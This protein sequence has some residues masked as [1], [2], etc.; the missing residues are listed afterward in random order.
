M[1]IERLFVTLPQGE[2]H[3]A[4]A[5]SGPPVLLLHQTP[6]SWDEY[7]DVLPLLGARYRAIAMDTIGFGDSVKPPLAAGADSI[8]NWAD[9]AIALLNVLE[10]ERAAVVGHHTGAAIAIELSA[11]HPD[12]ITG[13]VLSSAPFIRPRNH[14]LR[15]GGPPKRFP[16]DD[17]D[18]V[19][20][21]SHLLE[22]WRLRQ[23]DYPE[24]DIDLLERFIVDAIKAGP[25][26]SEGHWVV[27]RYVMEPRL[28]LIRCP[29]LLIAAPGDPHSYP[30]LGPL[31]RRLPHATVVE[32]PDG[33]VPLPDQLP[34]V[35]A[36]VVSTFL[37]TVYDDQS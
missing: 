19:P 5:G 9:A 4:I 28:A 16:V 13:A 32:I 23:P 2:I 11:A 24:G 29:V 26:A 34:A 7:R 37:D 30:S 14:E 27:A 21:G 25:R 1:N 17:V 36:S 31:S 33:R 35:F 6:R 3:C 8:E 22:L 15:S 12:R 20:D 18:R 10:V